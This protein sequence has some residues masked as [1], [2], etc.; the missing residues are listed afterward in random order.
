MVIGDLI[1]AGT[2]LKGGYE[3]AHRKLDDITDISSLDAFEQRFVSILEQYLNNVFRSQSDDLVQ[4]LIANRE[5]IFSSLSEA[6]IGDRDEGVELLLNSITEILERELDAEIERSELRQ[7]VETA[8]KEAIDDFVEKASDEDLQKLRTELA[9]DIQDELEAL[10]KSLDSRPEL[11]SEVVF[12]RINPEQNSTWKQ[13]LQ[14]VL[15]L[16][17]TEFPFAKPP[18]FDTLT[19]KSKTKILVVGLKGGG[20][21]RTLFECACRCVEAHNVD[22]IVVVTDPVDESTD[23]LE[24]A[25]SVHDE[26]VLLLWDDL[27]QSRPEEDIR[28]SLM[29]LDSEFEDLDG[30]L[31][32]RAAVRQRE[33]TDVLPEN[34][35]LDLLEESVD[36]SDTYAIWQ[37]FE[38]VE[39]QLEA[40]EVESFIRESLEDQEL[41]ASEEVIEAFVEKVLEADPT[42]FYIHS[43]CDNTDYRL[44]RNDIQTLPNDAVATWESAFKNL[45]EQQKQV[46]QTLRILDEIEAKPGRKLAKRLF[47]SIFPCDSVEFKSLL[48]QVSERGWVDTQSYSESGIPSDEIIAVHDVRLEAIEVDFD[49]L[50][51]DITEFLLSDDR[52][53]RGDRGAILNVSYA[54]KV[55]AEELG[56]DPTEDADRH[57]E[58]AIDQNRETARIHV[59]YARYLT[60]QDQYEAADEQWQRALDLDENNRRLYAAWLRKRGRVEDAKREYEKGLDPEPNRITRLRYS[61]GNYLEEIEEIERA[62]EVF[63]TGIEHVPESSLFAFRSS[64]FR[65]L[66][67][68][69]HTEKAINVLKDGLGHDTGDRWFRLRLTDL[70]E[71][72]G[73]TDEAIAVLE[74]GLELDPEKSKLRRRLAELVAKQDEPEKAIEIYERGLDRELAAVLHREALSGLLAQQNEI[75]RAIEVCQNGLEHEPEYRP[76]RHRLIE[77]LEDRDQ[78]EAVI[79][80]YQ[81]GIDVCPRDSLLRRSFAEVLEESR[82]TD[83]ARSVYEA[84][85]KRRPGDAPLRAQYARFLAREGEIENAATEYEIA[86]SHG[87]TPIESDATLGLTD[88]TES[89]QPETSESANSPILIEDW[90]DLEAIRDGLSDQYLLITDLTPE[91]A[92]Y[93]EVVGDPESGWQPIGHDDQPFSGKFDGGGHVITELRIDCP[94]E[95]NVGLFGVINDA[96]I[97]NLTLNKPEVIGGGPNVGSVV[98]KSKEGH[99]TDLKIFNGSVTA[100]NSV[101]GKN[102]GG[103]AGRIDNGEISQAIVDARIKSARSN[104]G[105]VAGRNTD[106]TVEYCWANVTIAARGSNHGGIAGYNSTKDSIVSDCA[107]HVLFYILGPNPAGVVGLN[108]GRVHRCYAVGE[109]FTTEFEPGGVVAVH[110]PTS[111][112]EHAY[113]EQ[114]IAPDAAKRASRRGGGT[115]TNVGRLQG[116]A[117]YGEKAKTT[118]RGF[119]FEETWETITE[120]HGNPRLDWFMNHE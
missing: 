88:K 77:L 107:S 110:R 27:Q 18:G 120:P 68:N 66:K 117:L 35:G 101:T 87:W 38:K 13:N 30:E 70:L 92:G 19:D 3:K 65:L 36:P 34:R 64:F 111:E 32:V 42:P 39:L 108:N 46:L 16:E 59:T 23:L 115:I 81:G 104:V 1:T 33:I 4:I 72:E 10:K 63:E 56:L 71:K 21:T 53:L 29:Q 8:Y 45:P 103:V 11:Y 60:D 78:T 106:G 57:F 6:K 109:A 58:R 22:T 75:N 116:E 100:L 67:R 86:V 83:R 5:D 62:I 85:L 31:I 82:Y 40:A 48:K 80:A 96:D 15:Q 79:E 52:I 43:V 74:D 20:K 91:S 112:I 25:N 98:G 61:Y 113:W 102:I 95:Q 9:V 7:A 47:A 90:T 89:K 73:R 54:K 41:A 51:P 24:I 12:E 50:H 28:K 84:G 97:T 37:Q 69:G 94:D 14:Q 76:F 99:L 114:T 17:G 26:N 118:L 119:D 44:E 105:G 2:L 55:Y 49:R 93:N